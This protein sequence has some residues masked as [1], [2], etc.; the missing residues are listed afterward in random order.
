[1]KLT[2]LKYKVFNVLIPFFYRFL[3]PSSSCPPPPFLLSPSLSHPVSHP[4]HFLQSI[5]PDIS[6]PSY[7]LLFPY[8][9][10]IRSSSFPS[11]SFSSSPFAISLFISPDF[12][13]SKSLFSFLSS[14]FPVHL[15]SPFSLLLSRLISLHPSCSFSILSLLPLRLQSLTLV[16]LSAFSFFAFLLHSLFPQLFSPLVSAAIFISLPSRPVHYLPFPHLFLPFSPIFA[17]FS[18]LLP[19]PLILIT[20]PPHTSLLSSPSP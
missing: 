2:V 14:F 3:P 4:S 6:L 20:F 9:L 19:F 18:S 1:M 15:Y 7:P 5:L 12:P 10:T 11:S 13:Q 17:H 8:Y 16:V